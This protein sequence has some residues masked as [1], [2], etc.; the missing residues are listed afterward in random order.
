MALVRLY[1][2]L[3]VPDDMTEDEEHA[4]MGEVQDAVAGSFPAE[5]KWYVIEPDYNGEFADKGADPD[6]W[7][8]G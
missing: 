6:L 8:E 4:M 7:S 3:E 2:V 1:M 5:T